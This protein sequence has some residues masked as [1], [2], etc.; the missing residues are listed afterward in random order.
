[1]GSI[2]KDFFL[3]RVL[4]HVEIVY[5]LLKWNL[6]QSWEVKIE[7]CTTSKAI[8]RLKSLFWK[9]CRSIDYQQHW[10]VTWLYFIVFYALSTNVFSHLMWCWYCE[11][12]GNPSGPFR[13][14]GA[15]FLHDTWWGYLLSEISICFCGSRWEEAH[16]GLN[17]LTYCMCQDIHWPC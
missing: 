6:W 11:C 9:S 5:M 15:F 4:D 3:L 12:D 17:G 13:C 14:C 7:T 2:E 16:T 8:A 10:K 1:M